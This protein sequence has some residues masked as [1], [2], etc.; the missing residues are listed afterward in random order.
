MN[1]KNP[2]FEDNVKLDGSTLSKE[3]LIVAINKNAS[4]ENTT[5]ANQ[6]LT[7][8]LTRITKENYSFKGVK[9]SNVKVD[10]D[11]LLKIIRDNVVFENQADLGGA[12]QD[13]LI[14]LI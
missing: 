2:T 9:F 3:V 4:L 13:T 6:D 5:I 11:T 12:A 1:L 8:L 10:E 14:T 7:G